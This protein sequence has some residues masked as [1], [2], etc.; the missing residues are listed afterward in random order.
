M[1]DPCGCQAELSDIARIFEVYFVSS[2]RFVMF[3]LAFM[4]LCKWQD[5]FGDI[6]MIIEATVSFWGFTM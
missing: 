4:D 2:F 3:W 6:A 5:G 1:R